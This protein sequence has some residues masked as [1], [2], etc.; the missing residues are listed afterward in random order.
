MQPRQTPAGNSLFLVAID[1]VERPAKIFARACF[2]FDEN[3]GVAIAADDVDLA[4]AASAKISVENFVTIAAQEAG[5]QFLT[6][7]SKPKMFGTRRRK[8]VAP[9]V[10]KIGDESDKDR[11]HAI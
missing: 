3:E 10:R 8:P 1:R 2:H 11:V 7:R 9:P 6:P 5:R 4:A